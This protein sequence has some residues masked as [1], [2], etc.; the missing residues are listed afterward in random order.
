MAK[1]I[2]Y[3][4][5]GKK[6]ETI[7]LEGLAMVPAVFSV[8][9]WAGVLLALLCVMSLTTYVERSAETRAG[10]GREVWLHVL[11][12]AHGLVI[13]LIATAVL[14]SLYVRDIGHYVWSRLLG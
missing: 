8:I 14:Y 7:A 13:G 9:V 4:D 5:Q 12:V 2:S 3:M 6:A 11:L 10:R 1:I